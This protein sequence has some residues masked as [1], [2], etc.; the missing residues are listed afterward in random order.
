MS[1]LEVEPGSCLVYED[2]EIG[3]AS[4]RD[5]GVGRIVDIRDWPAG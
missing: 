5:A 4:A 2:S 1:R 3:M